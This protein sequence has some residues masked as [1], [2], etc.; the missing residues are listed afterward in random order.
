[1]LANNHVL[2]FGYAGLLETLDTLRGAG[3]K[4]AG[5]GRSLAEALAPA[6]LEL[7]AGARVIVFG[8][9]T[10]TS[11]VTRSW[12]ATETRPGVSVLPDLSDGTVGRIGEMVTGVKRRRD[13]VIAS[14]HWG[15]N[16][17]F[18]VPDSHVRF[19]H[20]LIQAGVDVVHGHSS[21]HVRPIEIF[22]NRLILYGCGDLLNDYEGIG[23][24]E[25]FRADLA[26]MFF[27][28]IDVSTGELCGLH[29]TPMR[30]RNFRLNRASRA[31]AEWLTSTIEHES[32]RFGVRLRLLDDDRLELRG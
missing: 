5:A 13:V 1:V 25:E 18:A 10:T 24:Y 20:G 26:L 3:M 23:G 30:I 19:A 21:H 12:A 4:T 14:I 22:E 8:L 16:W 9:G 2:D 32:K 31:D 27:P 15:S 6:V 28:S 7:T 11:G 29:L 17:G